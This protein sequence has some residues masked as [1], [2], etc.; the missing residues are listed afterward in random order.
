MRVW[1]LESRTLGYEALRVWSL[2]FRVVGLRFGV[3][4]P[5]PKP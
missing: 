1:G 2:G 3:L 5:K 4:S